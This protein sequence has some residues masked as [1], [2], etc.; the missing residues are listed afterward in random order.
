MESPDQYK[1]IKFDSTTSNSS[2]WSHVVIIAMSSD[3]YHQTN[4][5]LDVKCL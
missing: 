4:E 5:E 3:E 2:N 1:Q